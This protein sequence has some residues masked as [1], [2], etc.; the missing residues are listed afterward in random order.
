MQKNKKFAVL[1]N[2]GG[3]LAAS[4]A[5]FT[6]F[7]L[8]AN[9]A[10]A[11]GFVG[12]YFFPPTITTDDPFAT[13]ELL[14]P[15]VSY[16]KSPA[17]GGSPA[18]GTTDVGWSF[19]KE[20]FP[21]FALSISGDYL[22]QKPDG[23]KLLT[24]WDDFAMNAKY[25]L[26]QNDAHQAIFSIGGDWD[27]GGSGSKQVGADPS[28]T[29]TPIIYGGK[30]F[31]NLPNS[32]KYARPIAVT[33]TLGVDLPT[34]ADPN[35]LNW[36]IALEYSLPYLQEQVK[37]IGLPRPFRD[38]I[39]VVE[40]SMTSPLNRGG[41]LTTGTINPGVMYE[42]KYFQIG[43]EALIP[44]NSASG[45]QVGGIVQLQIYIDDIWPKVFGFPLIG[46]EQE[47]TSM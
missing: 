20:I 38:M 14:L 5:V 39:P 43:A 28:S 18:V 13:D 21:R 36:G 47:K 1:K 42:T 15:S 40:F 31:G 25:Q 7:G 3:W 10:C 44:V 6:A 4:G 32:L 22:F 2:G 29:F 16:F 24:G 8:G 30:A 9:G 27:I 37:D 11:H 26:W 12:D 41:G 46:H 19:T 23:Q 34:N 33:G 45:H 17:G 35:N